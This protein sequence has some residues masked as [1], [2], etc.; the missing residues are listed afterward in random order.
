MDLFFV[1]EGRFGSDFRPVFLDFNGMTE[2]PLGKASTNSDGGLIGDGGGASD[3]CD[4]PLLK[5]DFIFIG[6]AACHSGWKDTR[7][8]AG[9][10]GAGR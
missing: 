8:G 5:L 9:D 1:S 6:A 2:Y 7:R 10:G 4:D 3:E